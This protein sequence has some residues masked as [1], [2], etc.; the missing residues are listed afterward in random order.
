VFCACFSFV[1][2]CI[3][4]LESPCHDFNREFSVLS[5]CES[6]FFAF[7]KKILFFFH[8]LLHR[9]WPRRDIF[10][11]LCLL[12][13]RQIHLCCFLFISLFSNA[14]FFFSEAMGLDDARVERMNYLLQATQL[15]HQLP[16][17]NL[18]ALSQHYGAVLR[19]VARKSVA[20]ISSNVK[21][22]LCRRC[23]ALLV[24]GS[25]STVRLRARAERHLVVSCN[26]CGFQQRKALRRDNRSRAKRRYEREHA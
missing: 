12:D 17:R 26:A 4:V 7:K 13:R 23:D 3:S 14:A 24:P 8:A 18:S 21:K 19:S 16:V 11:I 22:C 1:C 6:K 15:M 10:V 5:G 2:V 25:T 9:A 20:T